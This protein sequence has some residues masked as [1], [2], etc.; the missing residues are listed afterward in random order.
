[1]GIESLD[2]LLHSL[3]SEFGVSAVQSTECRALNEDGVITIIL[4]GAQKLSDF[5]L[6]K[7]VHLGVSNHVTLV[8]EDDDVLDTDLS[9]EQNMLSGLWHGTIGSRHDED[10]TVHAG[11]TSDHILYVI[12]VAWAINVTVMAG[13]RL[14]LDCGSIDGDTSG[15]LLRGSIDIVIVLELSLTYIIIISTQKFN[16]R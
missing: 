2:K 10:T 11:G 12:C 4:V 9:A 3:L 8:E 16:G 15:L 1:M 14:V 5:H 13:S 6:D 7:L